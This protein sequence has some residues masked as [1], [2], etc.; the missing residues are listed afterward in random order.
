MSNAISG[1]GGPREVRKWQLADLGDTQAELGGESDLEA[2]AKE[3]GSVVA[4]RARGL[5]ALDSL[6]KDV[7][8]AK[9]WLR[10]IEARIKQ[11]RRSSRLFDD[12]QRHRSNVN[13][14]PAA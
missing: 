9:A 13:L 7:D 11:L 2:V 5:H 6:E 10:E 12:Q 14:P 4:E 1:D 8:V 3:L